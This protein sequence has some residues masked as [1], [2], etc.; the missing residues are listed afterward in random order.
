MMEMKRALILTLRDLDF[1]FNYELWDE[2]QDRN[3]NDTGSA[4]LVYGQRM[5]RSGQAMG[6]A[7]NTNNAIPAK[8]PV[9]LLH[10]GLQRD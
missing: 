10:R 4:R 8:E 3:P 2:L 7:P 9:V 6:G 1:D 5:Y